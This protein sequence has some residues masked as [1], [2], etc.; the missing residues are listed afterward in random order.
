MENIIDD[1]DSA[2]NTSFESSAG[3]AVGNVVAIFFAVGGLCDAW[4]VVVFRREEWSDG[5]YFYFISHI[6]LSLVEI[7]FI[8]IRRKQ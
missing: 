6:I 3:E 2:S 7:F 1:I 4:C 8:T 5:V